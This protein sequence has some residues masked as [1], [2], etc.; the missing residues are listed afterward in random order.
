M[1]TDNFCFYLQ[2]RLIQTSQTGGQQ[3]S[4]TSP[5]SIPRYHLQFWQNFP[6]QFCFVHD[7]CRVFPHLL[8]LA[9]HREVDGA[10]GARL[11]LRQ[12]VGVGVVA[13][14]GQALEDVQQE[15]DG[16]ERKEVFDFLVSGR[17]TMV[18]L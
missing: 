5:S 2:N 1:K 4:D 3:Y 15:L 16:T 8:H 11:E 13:V 7:V 6:E 10:E 9:V 18:E 12:P 14:V 17:S